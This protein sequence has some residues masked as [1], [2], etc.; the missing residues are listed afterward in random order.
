MPLNR[1]K[2]RE[3]IFGSDTPAGETFDLVLLAAIL[4]SVLTVILESVPSIQTDYA[5]TIDVLEWIFTIIFTIEYGARIWCAAS[6][7]RYM[8]SFFG[9]VDFLSIIP[10]YVSLLFPA[11]HTLLIVRALRLLRIFRILKL[12]RYMKEASILRTAILAS[13]QKIIVFLLTVAIILVIAASAMYLIEGQINENF[14]SIPKTLYWSIVTL[15]T[16]GYGDATPITVL[17]KMLAAI[18]MLIGY[19]MI[20]I[21][22]GILTVEMTHAARHS[23]GG[24]PL[25]LDKKTDAGARYCRGCGRRLT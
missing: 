17:G 25:C 16:V 18:M 3:I 20:I 5:I 8:R 24:C 10:T 19:S 13:R 7:L 21:P 12:G 9:V 11:S 4:L 15:T 2:A 22:T 23:D 6:A 1:A 14:D